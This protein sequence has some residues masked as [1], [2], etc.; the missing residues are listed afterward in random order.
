MIDVKTATTKEL[1]EF[2]NANTT[3]SPVK[4]FQDRAT[5]ERR[6]AELLKECCPNCGVHLSNGVG[7]HGDEVNGEIQ[8][9]Q[10][11][12]KVCLGCGEEFG[13]PLRE[14]QVDAKRSVGVAK[15]WQDP[16]VKAK[17]STRHFVRVN[18]EEFRSVRAAFIALR[19]PLNEHIKF[20]MELK[21][22]GQ[23]NAYGKSWEAFEV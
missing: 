4:K 22:E 14:V 10:R 23:L 6:V 7:Y 21:A 8:R 13:E 2:Y 18:G 15:S 16:E 12:D 17:R 5:A 11:F 9:H 3:G 19:L 20:R 1:V